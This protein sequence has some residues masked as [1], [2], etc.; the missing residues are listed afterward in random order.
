M[1]L[2]QLNLTE[3]ADKGAEL[4]LEHPVSGEL[5]EHDGKPMVIRLSGT[6]SAAY[7]KKQREHQNKRLAKM[8]KGRKADFSINDDEA[9]ELL[10]ACTLGWSNIIKDGEELDFS[11]DAAFDLYKEFPWMREQVDAF[12]GD[13]SNFFTKA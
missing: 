7:R 6:D 3:K 11:E 10:A 5:L 12:I 4:H 13:R 9:C 2:N 8:A 1:D